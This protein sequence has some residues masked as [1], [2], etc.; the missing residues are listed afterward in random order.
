MSVFN[1]T[2]GSMSRYQSD[3]NYN[4]DEARDIR[5]QF[6]TREGTY[7]LL[8]HSEYARPTRLPMTNGTASTNSNLPVKVSLVRSKD[9]ETNAVDD[10]LCFN[11]GKEIYVYP[12]NG[13]K[14]VIFLIFSP[15]F[16]K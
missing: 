9:A 12:Y 6:V 7:K 16:V 1:E 13:I 2:L 14:K 11:I 8:N 5:C 10:R 3:P 4:R 15:K